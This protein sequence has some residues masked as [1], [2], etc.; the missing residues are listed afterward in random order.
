MALFP[1]RTEVGGHAGNRSASAPP[2]PQRS[3]LQ[4]NISKSQLIFCCLALVRVSN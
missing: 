4:P 3:A 2:P 1:N